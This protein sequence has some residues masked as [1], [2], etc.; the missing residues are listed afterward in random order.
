ML[1]NR[2][3]PFSG[4]SQRIVAHALLRAAS[5]L[6]STRVLMAAP[7]LC[8]AAFLGLSATNSL[9]ITTES[10]SS[11]TLG[12]VY[13]QKL[14]AAGGAAP[15]TWS[16]RSGK[17]PGG[18][19]LSGAGVL[20]GWPST[21]GKSSFT[22]DVTDADHRSATEDFDLLVGP[23]PILRPHVAEVG[24]DAFGSEETWR[25]RH[26]GTRSAMGSSNSKA[27]PQS[28]EIDTASLPSGTTQNSYLAALE[29]SGGTAPYSWSIGSGQL[30]TG[31]VL[32]SATGIISGTPTAAGTYNFT[33]QM[34][35]PKG[36]TAS[37]LL[38]IAVALCSSCGTPSL[39]ITPSTLPAGTVNTAYSA[40]L[41]AKGGTAPYSWSLASGALP[42]GLTLSSSGGIAG[43]PT[44]A[45]S[46]S[47]AIKAG[48]S[49]GHNVSHSY[50]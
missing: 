11:G 19:S 24:S 36:L 2:K 28:L 46:Y 48:D 41:A 43:T 27:D 42:T 5:R 16:V 26:R 50:S 40:T 31:V 13:S 22:L 3:L 38:G 18:L 23:P 21:T 12:L 30:P 14:H 34:K 7:L 8:F 47:F 45:G 33:V 32:N 20:W 35:D 29:G 9:K 37:G 25:G 44:N 39:S 6:F 4:S 1:L 17:L 15:Y 10:L 49:A